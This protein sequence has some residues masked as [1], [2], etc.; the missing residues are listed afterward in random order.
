MCT[1]HIISRPTTRYRIKSGR[2]MVNRHRR[3]FYRFIHGIET[4]WNGAC[5]LI[6]DM[7]N[8]V[9]FLEGGSSNSRRSSDVPTRATSVPRTNLNL[10][11]RCC[12]GCNRYLK[13][14]QFFG[15]YTNTEHEFCVDCRVNGKPSLPFT[16]WGEP[17]DHSTYGER[18]RYYQSRYNDESSVII[19]HCEIKI[20]PPDYFDVDIEEASEFWSDPL[21]HG[22]LFTT[23]DSLYDESVQAVKKRRTNREWNRKYRYQPW[24]YDS[25]VT[26]PREQN[27][28]ERCERLWKHGF[29]EHLPEGLLQTASWKKFWQKY[30]LKEP[31]E[32]L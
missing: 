2:Q 20:I 29:D 9:E 19:K 6:H 13:L 7:V 32:T 12:P 26:S 24:V 3:R 16:L 27:M 5:M 28:R 18:Q 8:P 11:M 10:C 4:F 25:A 30:L 17:V 14:E 1:I 21:L 31:V 23:W 22:E 15:I